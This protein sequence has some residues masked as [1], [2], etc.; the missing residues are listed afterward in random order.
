L[1]A[2]IEESLLEEK[3]KGDGLENS[4][5]MFDIKRLVFADSAFSGES[6]EETRDLC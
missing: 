4:A 1:L 5:K 3:M 6:Q 2:P